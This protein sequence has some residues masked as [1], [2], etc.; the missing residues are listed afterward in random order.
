MGHATGAPTPVETTSALRGSGTVALLLVAGAAAV[1]AVMG[2]KLRIDQLPYH[3]NVWGIDWLAYYEPQGRHLRMGHVLGWAFSW[4]GL[5]P[6]LSGAV[7]S[8]LQAVGAGFH[9]HW[10]A[11]VA[12]TLAAP[13]LLAGAGWHRT[14]AVALLLGIGWLWLS[15][16]QANYGL[17]TSPYPWTLLAVA[18]STVALIRALERNT[19]AAWWL[20]AW[21]TALAAQTH[22]LAAAAV[23]G[24][25]LLLVLH[26]PGWIKARRDAMR[27][28]GLVVGASLVLVVGMSVFKTMDSW[29]F[30]IGEEQPWVGTARHVLSSRFGELAPKWPV[31]AVV[32]LGVVGGLWRGPRRPILLMLVQ[33]FGYLAALVLFLG[34]HVADPRLTHYYVVPHMLLICAGAWGLGALGRDGRWPGAVVVLALALAASVPWGR[35]AADWF[36]QRTTEAAVQIEVSS[37]EQVAG[38]WRD[39]GDGD[40]VVYLWDHRFLNDEPENMDPISA[41]WPTW[42]TGRPCFAVEDPPLRCNAHGG[43]LFYFSPS[44][45]SGELE[46]IEETLRI[47][48]NQAHR[49]GRATL[50]VAP[51]PQESPPRPW[52]MDGWL[53]DNG[54]V[55]HGPWQDGVLAWEFPVGAVVPE[56][57]PLDPVP[58]QGAYEDPP[59]SQR[60]RG[61]RRRLDRPHPPT[62]DADGLA[63]DVARGGAHQEG[64][65]RRSLQRIGQAPLRDRRQPAG[66]D[67]VG[68]GAT[69]PGEDRRQGV[70]PLGVGEARQD[71]VDRHPGWQLVRQRLGPGGHGA[72]GGVADPQ[73]RDRLTDRG[74]HDVHD[75]AVAG[76]PHPWQGRPDQ[77]V[78][79]QKVAAKGQQEPVIVRVQQRAGRRSAGVVDQHLDR[80]PPGQQLPHHRR[81]G[82]PVVVVRHH[83]GRV[84][85][86]GGPQPLH[87][88]GQ[89]VPGAGQS[90]DPSPPGPQGD[91]DGAADAGA[92]ATHQRVKSGQGGLGEVIVAHGRGPTP[93]R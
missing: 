51:D 32:G 7:H 45:F 47:M 78:S 81:Q 30:H 75:P 70:E 65:Q 76:L 72:P 80:T 11:T 20:S 19:P 85:G 68:R 31:W 93:A 15:P 48:I 18:G 8:A 89:G 91:G 67:R 58:E 46:P 38:Y 56:P 27:R 21:L 53:Q 59:R 23:M 55:L 90:G 42:R 28:W 62:V 49:P 2:V 66:L 5:H 50:V 6:P 4:Q 17:N 54:A 79:G 16:M 1:L 14:S 84:D 83:E 40:V 60:S 10:T 3:Q 12:A 26:G 9:V 71:V 73:A 33:A 24:Q 61:D 44:A 52:P 92:G 88:G 41:L 25:V 64:H 77:Q 36:E 82:R 87:Q 86:P 13:L 29:T 57:P 22:I 39:A 37:A 63:P 69:R 35:S 34:I 43:S 74:G